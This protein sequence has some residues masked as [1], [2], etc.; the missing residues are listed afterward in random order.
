MGLWDLVS[1][2]VEDGLSLVQA[3]NGIRNG[4]VARPPDVGEGIAALMP[5]SDELPS[6]PAPRMSAATAA[7]IDQAHREVQA[8]AEVDRREMEIRIRARQIQRGEI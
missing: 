1:P 6:Q 8:Q 2:T 7:S 4:T 3:L 5:Q